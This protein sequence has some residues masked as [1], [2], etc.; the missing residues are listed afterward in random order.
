MDDLTRRG[1]G[2]YAP[3]A[4]VAL[5]LTGFGLVLLGVVDPFADIPSAEYLSHIAERPQL[6][7]GAHLL[8]AAAVLL[9]MTGYLA[10]GL[11]AKG[12]RRPVA[13]V[14]AVLAALGALLLVV[15]MVRDGYVHGFL[16]ERWAAAAPTDQAFWADTF[17]ASLRTSYGTELASM[18]CLLALA[19]AVLSWAVAATGVVPRWV[20]WVG[21]VQGAGALT[22][23]TVLWMGGPSELGY[24]ALYPVFGVALPNVW[25]LA[26]AWSLRSVRDAEPVAATVPAEATPRPALEWSA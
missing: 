14:G 6:W 5:T 8:V 16:A 4:G 20:C 3:I 11:V 7:L 1:L 9:K 2:F 21:Y 13:L 23:A 25:L 26:V 15:T 12:P 22:T 24:G 19:P 17:A 10:L 18:I